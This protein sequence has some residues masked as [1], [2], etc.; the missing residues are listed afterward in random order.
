[1]SENCI[2]LF[3]DESGKNS[4]K[5]TLMGGL[6]IPDTVY[7]LKEFENL[8]ALLKSAQL[9]L[10]WNEY[11]GGD[12]DRKNISN[13]IYS[14]MQYATMFKFNVIMYHKP[15]G[16]D[17]NSGLFKKM[18]YNKLP[19]R[20]LYGLLRH[21][22]AV[23]TEVEI[24]IEK[25][26]E[27]EN[28]QLNKKI[29][30]QLNI[31]SMYRGEPFHI[32][33]CCLIPKGKEIGLEL[34]DLILGIIRT[35]IKNKTNDSKGNTARNILITELLKNKNF[36][37]FLINIKFF[38]WTAEKVLRDVDFNDYLQLFLSK[39]VSWLSYLHSLPN[40]KGEQ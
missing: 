26:T 32:R 9:K 17:Y 31:H 33:N 12:N 8:S 23:K 25:S 21:G 1:M 37:N 30:D 29:V 5:P 40:Y 35:I 24:M 27:Y 3:F 18:V 11:S 22:V 39:Q 20:I 38:E 14:L 6:L 19:E 2:R 15:N 34:T 16:Q 28:T 13:V 36:Y 10:H 7:R 4:D